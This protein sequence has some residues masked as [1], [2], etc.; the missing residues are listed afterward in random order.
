MDGGADLETVVAVSTDWR[1]ARLQPEEYAMLEFGEKLTLLPS[2]M[3]SEDVRSLRQ[4]GFCDRDILSIT[5]ASAYRN[6][7]TRVAD[8]LGVELDKDHTI[9]V[10]ILEAFGVT[11]EESRTTMY[12]DRIVASEEPRGAPG[13]RPPRDSQRVPADGVCWIGTDPE[14]SSDLLQ[15]AEQATQPHPLTNLALAFSLR[16]DALRATLDFGRLAGMGGSGLGPRVEA[17]IGLVVAGTL[18]VSY[19]GVHHAQALLDSGARPDDVEALVRDPSGGTLAGLE[20]A[21][22]RFVEKLTRLPGEMARSDLDTLRHYGLDDSA[23]MTVVGSGSFEFFLCSAA[24][25][26]GVTLEDHSFAQPAL[27]A[28]EMPVLR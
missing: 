18:G 6:F 16:P 19:M 27:E 21:V 3:T 1:K 5:Q 25:A 9:P 8:G 24:A 20:R 28:F 13:T 17:I 12:G 23:A 11:E 14:I 7:I 4:H 15:D 22:A 2:A 26:L 10:E